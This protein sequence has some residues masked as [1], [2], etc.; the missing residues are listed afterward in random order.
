MFHGE[1]SRELANQFEYEVLFPDVAFLNGISRA[2]MNYSSE[3]GNH[4]S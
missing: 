4:F 1:N 2:S 3:L